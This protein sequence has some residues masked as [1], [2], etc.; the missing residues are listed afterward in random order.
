MCLLKA[1]FLILL[2]HSPSL[3]EGKTKV[4]GR[5]LMAGMLDLMQ[6]SNSLHS[7]RIAKTMGN[8]L[9]LARQQTSFYLAS[10]LIQHG[11]IFSRDG[12][13]CNGLGNPTGQFLVEAPRINAI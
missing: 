2:G 3:R 13:T 11:L 8:F 12:A 1:T 10:F 7:Q 5:N 4:Q 6:S 9:L